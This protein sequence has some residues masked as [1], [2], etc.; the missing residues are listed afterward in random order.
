MTSDMI[1][2]IGGFAVLLVLSAACEGGHNPPQPDP[3]DLTSMPFTVT[4]PGYLPKGFESRPEV[5]FVEVLN[6]VVILYTNDHH[7]TTI[8]LRQVEDAAMRS[9]PPCSDERASYTINDH[10]AVV[11][12]GSIGDNV[13]YYTLY[14]RIDDLRVAI[15]LNTRTDG[16]I[17]DED[18]IA[19]DVR[20]IAESIMGFLIF[21]AIM[22]TGLAVAVYLGIKQKNGR[23]RYVRLTTVASIQ[24]LKL[25][26]FRLRSEGISPRVEALEYSAWTTSPAAFEVLVHRRDV[27]KATAVLGLKRHS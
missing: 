27:E 15:D 3:S 14:F 24:E 23:S 4:L 26:E 22:L 13:F 18:Q 9:C 7:S 25:I 16:S 8:A 2:L 19:R 10:P 5:S 6:E 21:V 20:R 11:Q 12:S 17:V 1:R